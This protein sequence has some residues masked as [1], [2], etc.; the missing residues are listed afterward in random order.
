MGRWTKEAFEQHHA[1]H[2][3][4]FA[5]FL[6]Y[7]RMAK[8]R[9]GYYSAKC[10]FHRVRWETEID[11]GGDFKIDDGWISHYSRK[12]MDEFPDEFKDFFQT[13]VRA[14]GYHDK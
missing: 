10:I 8:K 9:R 14:G 1:A 11:E 7:A 12:L 3:E 2:P 5:R 6:H 4:I 13:R